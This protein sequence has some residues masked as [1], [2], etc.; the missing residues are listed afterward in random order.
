VLSAVAARIAVAVRPY[1]TL[2]R[3][4][5][6][7]FLVVLPK[8]GDEETREVLERIRLSVCDTPIEAEG[9]LVRV[10][11]SAGGASGCGVP[12][13]DLIRS[14]DQALYRAKGSGRNQV[15]MAPSKRSR[16]RAV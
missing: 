8:A 14:A 7:E 5:G 1:D 6:E 16:L 9:E 4:G 12:V 10:A 2:G 15:A 3:F 11:L 13:E